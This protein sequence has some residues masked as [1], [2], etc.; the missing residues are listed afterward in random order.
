MDLTDIQWARLSSTFEVPQQ[1][2]GRSR[3]DPRP[4]MNGILWVLRTVAHWKD[5]PGSLS[6]L[7][8]LS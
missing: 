1:G 2:S 4:I 8:D 7:P 5:I 3:Q 6:S